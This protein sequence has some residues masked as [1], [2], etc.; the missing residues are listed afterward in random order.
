MAKQNNFK[1]HPSK[2]ENH[3]VDVRKGN[4]KIMFARAKTASPIVVWISLQTYYLHGIL[5]HKNMQIMGVLVSLLLKILNKCEENLR[6][7]RRGGMR[8]SLWSVQGIARIKVAGE[9]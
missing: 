5:K 9:M 7:E 6:A 2:K 1:C 3:A 4:K 8:Q